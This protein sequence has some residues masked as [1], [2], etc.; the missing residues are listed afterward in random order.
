[1]KARRFRVIA[2]GGKTKP[3]ENHGCGDRRGHQ[4]DSEAPKRVRPENGGDNQP[5][6]EVEPGVED[7]GEEAY[8]VVPGSSIFSG[9]PISA[10]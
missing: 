5:E 9:W 8:P 1:M 4:R 3:I 10:A 7:E 2:G 6:Q